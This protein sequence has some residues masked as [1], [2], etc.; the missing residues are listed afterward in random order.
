[1]QIIFRVTSILAVWSL[2][3]ANAIAAPSLID[4]F[5][6]TALDDGRLITLTGSRL[7]AKAQDSAQNAVS[8]DRS[9]R[10]SLRTAS[11]VVFPEGRALH[12]DDSDY[13]MLVVNRPSATNPQ[14]YCGAG[15]E[16]NLY[17]L[18]LKQN[19]ANVALS[20]R[21]QSCLQNVELAS[22][23]VQSPYKSIKWTSSPPGVRIDWENDGKGQA[24][25]KTY[26]LQG[27]VFVESTN[28]D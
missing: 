21:L 26:R 17:V 13:F 23:G 6:F 4:P 24:V 18:K 16:G 14:G 12:I 11:S 7:T 10:D 27:S 5:T 20:L 15:E 19:V 2:C 3:A 25:T 8:I 9:V 22:D 28:G 1:M